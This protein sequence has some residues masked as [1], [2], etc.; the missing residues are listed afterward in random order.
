VHVCGAFSGPALMEMTG[1]GVREIPYLP[2]HYDFKNGK[3]WPNARPGLGV[4]FDASRVRMLAEVTQKNAPIP[5]FR[6]P[7]GSITNW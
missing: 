2:Q 1:E 3:M 7:D 4:E 5:L 6:R